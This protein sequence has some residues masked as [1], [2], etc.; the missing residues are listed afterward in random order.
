[1][2]VWSIIDQIWAIHLLDGLNP[3]Y[4]TIEPLDQIWTINQYSLW[5]NLNPTFKFVGDQIWTL[6]PPLTKPKP[7]DLTPLNTQWDKGSLLLIQWEGET[8]PFP[9]RDPNPKQTL[10]FPSQSSKSSR[11][12]FSNQRENNQWEER[13]LGREA[14]A[15]TPHLL[16][17]KRPM[18]AWSGGMEEL[19]LPLEAPSSSPSSQLFCV[20]WRA[21]FEVHA[22]WSSNPWG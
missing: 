4:L 7:L 17:F 3:S 16:R 10:L 14:G 8:S 6:H 20:P 5:L 9:K 15:Q 2:C 21:H 18:A 11:K 19:E 13:E 1:M 22:H 12:P